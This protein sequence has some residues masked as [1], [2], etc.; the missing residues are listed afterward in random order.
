MLT[1]DVI[2]F[3]Q[4]GSEV[5]YAPSLNTSTSLKHCILD[6]RFECVSVFVCSCRTAVF[7]R[8]MFLL[9]IW[10]SFFSYGKEFNFLEQHKQTHKS[11]FLGDKRH[12]E[13]LKALLT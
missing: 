1:N 12:Q 11:C 9:G 13:M 7:L 3:E 6:Q 8:T 10:L 4:F 5:E 2:S